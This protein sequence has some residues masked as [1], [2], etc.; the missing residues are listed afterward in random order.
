[1]AISIKIGLALLVL[2]TIFFLIKYVTKLFNWRA[3]KIVLQK[4]KRIKGIKFKNYTF[5]DAQRQVN[6]LLLVN[7][8]LK[9]VTVL[10]AIYIALPILFGIFP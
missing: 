5:F 4:D 1:M 3:T 7:K 8:V 6:A 9:W 2:L 10:F